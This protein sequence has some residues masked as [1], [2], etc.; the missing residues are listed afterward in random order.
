MGANK[1]NF[2]E[3]V[4][5]ARVE[6]IVKEEEVLTVK[7]EEVQRIV[8]KTNELIAL[9]EQA[10]ED[11]DEVKR[12]EYRNEVVVTNLRLVTQVLKKYGYFS[13]DKYQNGCIGLLKAAETY[14]SKK[15]VPFSN[16][17]CFCIETEIRLAFRRENRLF[18]SKNKGFLDSLDAPTVSGSSGDKEVYAHEVVSDPFAEQDF[19]RLIEEAE[20]DVLFYKVIIPC[21]EEYGRRS[22]NIDIAKW[23][24]LEIQYFIE[25]SM[26]HSQRQRLTL[27]EMARQLGTVVPNLRVRHQKV[28]EMIRQRCIQHGWYVGTTST[29]ATKVIKQDEAQVKMEAHTKRRK[30]RKK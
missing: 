2:T 3:E 24:E 23:C 8:S 17:A 1:I 19:D 28:L 27:S 11:G 26:E 21:I 9:M 10:K 13:P 16:Y 5:K 7:D 30:T 29:G 25:L 15:K 14:D 6:Q 22:I 20:L 4:A 18:E 12:R